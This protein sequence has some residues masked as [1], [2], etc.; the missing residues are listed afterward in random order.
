MGIFNFFKQLQL[1]ADQ[2]VALQK[3]EAFLDS[4]NQ[5]FLLKGYAGSGKTTI[6]K[7]LVEYL[8]AIDK[9]FALMAPTGRAA[10][11]V[12]ERTG[13]EAFTVHKSIYSYKEMVEE[14]DGE[15]FLYYFKISNNT[16]LTDKVFII[17]EASM[18]SDAKS[19]G[20]F[21]R[22]GTGRLLSDLITYTRITHLLV[23]SKIIFVG[24]PCQLPPVGDNSSKALDAIYLSDKFNVTV[25]EAE[26]KEVKRQGGES[27]ILKAASKLRKSLSSGYLNDFNLKENGEDIFN[28]S[29]ELFLQTWQNVT[30]S[31][32][33]IAYKNETCLKLNQQIREMKYGSIGLPIQKGDIIILGG[34]NYRKGVFNGEFAV[35]NEVSDMLKVE[36]VNF[37]VKTSLC[38]TSKKQESI[39]VILRWRAIELIFPDSESTNKVIKGQMLENFLNGD[40]ILRPEE[41]QAL[42]INFKNR[43]PDLKPHTAEFKK[44]IIDDEYFNCLLMKYGYAVTCHKAQGGEW[45]NVFTV[46][47]HDNQKKFD[48]LKDPQIRRGKDNL[49]FYRWAYTAVTRAAKTLFAL[50]PPAFNSYSNIAIMDQ[51]VVTALNELSGAA[52]QNEEIVLDDSLLKALNQ[53]GLIGQPIQMQDHFIN[54][55]NAVNKHYIE[56]LGWEKKNL[57]ISYQFKRED[58]IATLKTWVNKDAVFNGKYLKLPSSTNSDVFFKEVEDLLKNLPV[59]SIKRNTA[60]TIIS[61]MEFEFELE[62]KFPF[63]KNLFDDLALLLSPISVVIDELQHQQYK[64]RYTFK[65]GQES[66]VIDFE[67]NDK[68]FWGRVAP[69]K[70]KTNSQKLLNEIFAELQIFKKER[71]AG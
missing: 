52:K 23:N 36:T 16:D 61:N 69:L 27:G 29:Y 34:N 60:D 70:N 22:F 56:V 10:K 26:L 5:V 1:S 67:Y 50:N 39:Q 9:D 25:E 35:V 37:K 21:F 51:T 2:E 49:G 8:E 42:F 13:Q 57:E 30:S 63:T 46:W 45:D 15:S 31:K 68:G 19:E 33:I 41:T 58:K 14:K 20:E 62:E 12:H 55:R 7:G 59:H 3:L 47:D 17:D 4:S 38:E 18:L 65:R 11:V 44:A 24:D 43:H 28:P 32:I 53:L 40:N 71:Y 48:C 64:E 66:A 6:L 54:V